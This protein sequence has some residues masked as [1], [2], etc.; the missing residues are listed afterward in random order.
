[1]KKYKYFETSE[2]DSPDII[3]S[4]VNMDNDFMEMLEHAREIAGIPFKVNSGFRSENHNA[5]VGGVSKSSTNRGSS[6][7]YGFAADLSCTNSKDREVIIRCLVEAGFRRLGI[8]K[9]FIHVDNDPHKPN[10]VWLY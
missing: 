2:F 6:H 8:A 3:G 9:T 10:A 4:G 5:R 1:M 7:L